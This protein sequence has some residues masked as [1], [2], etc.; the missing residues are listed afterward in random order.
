[1]N[2]IVFLEPA[3]NSSKS[4]EAIA[5]PQSESPCPVP[6]LPRSRSILTAILCGAFATLLARPVCVA[7][8]LDLGPGRQPR[9]TVA[10]NGDV[11]VTFGRENAIF[12]TRSSDG[13]RSFEPAREIA[14][15]PALALGMRRGPRIVAVKDALLVTAVVGKTGMGRDGDILGWRSLDSGK[16][17]TALPRPINDAP[18]AAREGLHNLAVDADGS[19]VFCV[20]LDLRDRAGMTVYG[21]LSSDGG[22]TFGKNVLAY[23]SPDGHVCECCHPSAAFC[24]RIVDDPN[25]EPHN[26]DVVRVMFRNSLGGNRD[27]YVATSTDGGKTFGRGEQLDK[28]HWR[29]S[30]CPMDGGAIVNGPGAPAWFCAAYRRGSSVFF[31]E[32]SLQESERRIADGRQPA[33]CW[34][35]AGPLVVYT[36]A[37]GSLGGYVVRR[38]RH[39]RLAERGEDPVLATAPAGRTGTTF[40]AWESNAHVFVAAPIPP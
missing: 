36:A 1:M 29:L 6:M 28:E 19:R 4:R 39:F 34:S 2:H 15:V 21:A 26:A 18:D 17:W 8:P 11:L 13:G 25:S 31:Y 38:D 33:A 3:R 5:P 30:A 14:D 35:N 40:C 7:E 20:W 24:G 23:A 12:V 10:P 32:S 37:D 16:T 22:A 9:V 27:M